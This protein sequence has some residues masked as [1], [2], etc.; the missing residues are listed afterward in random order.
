MMTV[1]MVF[2]GIGAVVF[3]KL[4][5]IFGLGSLIRAGIGIYVGA[6]IL[7]FALRSSY[8]A[9]IIAR[10]LQG[11]GGSAIPALV[12]VVIARHFEPAERGQDLR[13]DHLDSLPRHRL[14]PG[15][16]GLVSSGP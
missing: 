16:R 6:S 2:F 12:F 1:F 10:A 14:R 9:V 4:S 13:H 3:G 11:V 8:P 15:H 7:G 5:D